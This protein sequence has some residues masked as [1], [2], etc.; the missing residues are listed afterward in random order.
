MLFGAECIIKEVSVSLHGSIASSL[1]RIVLMTN[2]E[3][4][5]SFCNKQFVCTYG[6]FKIGREV[7]ILL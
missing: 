7:K 1:K 2:R 6:M 5:R 3:T 4:I